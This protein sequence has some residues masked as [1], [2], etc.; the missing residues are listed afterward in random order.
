MGILYSKR[1][2]KRIRVVLLLMLVAFIVS[3]GLNLSPTV[4]LKAWVDKTC[5]QADAG[6]YLLLGLLYTVL[7]AIPFIPAIEFGILLMM[8]LGKPGILLAYVCTVCALTLSYFC[9]WA[10]HRSRP[11]PN[12]LQ[13]RRFDDHLLKLS[14]RP[15][16][17]RITE[18]FLRRPYIMLMFLFNLPGNA[19]LGGGGGIA[20]LSGASGLLVWYRYL[21]AVIV[22]TSPVPLLA[23]IGVVQFG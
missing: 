13:A 21:F 4:E 14:Q 12:R 3:W 1:I 22:A 5:Q 23:T 10:I 6:D 2:V 20:M 11:D 16:I 18:V 9:G 17:G 15:L 8:L 19:V 7:L